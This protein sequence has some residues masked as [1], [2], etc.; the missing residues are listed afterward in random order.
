MRKMMKKGNRRK[1]IQAGA[2]FLIS[3]LLTGAILVVGTSGDDYAVESFYVDEDTAWM[4]ATVY[5]T[6]FVA[7]ELPGLEDWDGAQVEKKPV[8]VYDIHGKKLFYEF[9]VTKDGK[10]IGVMVK[11]KACVGFDQ[12]AG[13]A[14]IISIEKNV[15]ILCRARKNGISAIKSNDEDIHRSPRNHEIIRCL[16]IKGIQ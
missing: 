13:N 7:D 8:T 14:G 16:A 9:P 2:V 11:G 10:A 6:Q 15:E 5:L 12:S 1:E 4:H 3:L